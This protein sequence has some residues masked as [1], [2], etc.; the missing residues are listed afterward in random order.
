MQICTFLKIILKTGAIIIASVANHK[1]EN[2]PM[3]THRDLLCKS[4]FQNIYF[5]TAIVDLFRHS[6]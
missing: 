4:I 3:C 1:R 6:Y 5:Q 2:V